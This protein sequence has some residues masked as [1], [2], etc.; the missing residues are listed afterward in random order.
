MP[1]TFTLFHPALGPSIRYLRRRAR[2]SQKDLR[3]AVGAHGGSLGQAWLSRIERGKAEP[4]ERMVDQI[5]AA[6]GSD[7]YELSRLIEQ[8]IED[9]EVAEEDPLGSSVASTWSAPVVSATVAPS[10]HLAEQAGT[11]PGHTGRAAC[12][13]PLLPEAPT[14]E[15]S[16]APTLAEAA[17]EFIETYEGL[18]DDGRRALLAQ[19]GA[20][21]A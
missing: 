18:D 11:S 10:F 15:P 3:T 21:R 1:K 13:L 6:L 7:R 8:P 4:S 2:M 20:A 16:T 9:L 19:V 5:L 12:T 17:T 14:A